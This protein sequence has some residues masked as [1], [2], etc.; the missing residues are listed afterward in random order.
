MLLSAIVY[1]ATYYGKTR[2]RFKVRNCE[3][4]DISQVNGKK[5]K[6]D[7]NKLT[8]IQEHLFC[9]NY[10]PSFHDFSILTRESHDFKLK[11]MNRLPIVR[12]KP[13][14]YKADASLRLELFWYNIRGY[15]MMFYHI[16]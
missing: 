9:C 15:N 2:R 7:N 12:D 5:V 16:T 11:I 4:L 14:I 8:A 10:S 3:H 6:I 13:V 1:N